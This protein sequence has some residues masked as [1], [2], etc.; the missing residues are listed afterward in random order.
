M[1]ISA[2]K[3]V[4]AGTPTQ[5]SLAWVGLLDCTDDVSIRRVQLVLVTAVVKTAIYQVRVLLQALNSVYT[6]SRPMD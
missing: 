4:P 2:E 6:F 1:T 5:A 3:I